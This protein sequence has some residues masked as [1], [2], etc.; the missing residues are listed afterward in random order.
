MAKILS[1][2]LRLLVIFA[3]TP[4]TTS[5]LAFPPTLIF[6]LPSATGMLTLLFPFERVPVMLPTLAEFVTDNDGTV[7]MPVNLSKLKPVLP[8][9]E[10]ASLN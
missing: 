10:P 4:V 7:S 9:N 6:T 3:P 5:T 1:L 8:P 2:T